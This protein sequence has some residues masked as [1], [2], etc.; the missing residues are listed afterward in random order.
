MDYLELLKMKWSSAS[1]LGKILIVV[2][3]I[4]ALAA[5][6]FVL[7][8]IAW[9]L[10][11]YSLKMLADSYAAELS[12][13]I[14]LSQPLLKAVTYFFLLLF[15]P[16]GG[17]IFSFRRKNRAIGIGLFIGFVIALNL[18]LGLAARDFKVNPLTSAP[19]KCVVLYNGKQTYYDLVPGQE[20][21]T[22]PT[23]GRRCIPVTPELAI[24]LTRQA[25]KRIAGDSDIEFFD[26]ATGYHKVWFARMSDNT[27]ELFDNE[28]FHPT[29]SEELLPITRE[30]GAEWKRQY[31]LK[32]EQEQRDIELKNE[33]EEARIVEEKRLAEQK[34]LEEMRLAEEE[35]AEEQR[36]AEENARRLQAEEDARL[37]QQQR[38]EQERRQADEERAR[39]G[40]RCDQ[41]AGNTYDQDRNTTLPGVSYDLLVSQAK[42]AV[43]ACRNAVRIDGDT[44]R[45][46]YQLARALQS[47]RSGEAE[48]ILQSLADENYAAAF[49]NLGWIK[50]NKGNAGQGILDFERGAQLG[51][52][53][54]MFS[55]G[56]F[57]YEGRLV[58]KDRQAGVN[59]LKMAAE[60][61]HSGAA[62]LLSKIRDGELAGE[63]FGTVFGTIL[64]EILK[65][66]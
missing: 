47:Q 21:Q 53:E 28:G 4:G 51:G 11:F 10:G 3:V 63:V 30:V 26:P 39:G 1:P 48:D 35:R 58:Q 14:P 66:R 46:Q 62:E 65:K 42:E 50:I 17:L 32:V 6:G 44:L 31:D 59:Y 15:I 45:Y 23:N 49:D 22:D 12:R 52:T 9:L 27:I 57:L 5:I 64:G 43:L 41:L 56:G 25:P 60:R 33:I 55:L 29:T 34:R 18:V 13:F 61:G 7:S 40:R 38:E 36:L 19:E 54:S 24:K 37:A 2:S 20:F 16:L 8:W